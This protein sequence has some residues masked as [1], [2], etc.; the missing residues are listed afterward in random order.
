MSSDVQIDFDGSDLNGF[1]NSETFVK[2][3]LN[4]AL[5]TIGDLLR[6]ALK[7]NTPRRNGKLANST[8][9]Q[10][11]GSPDD[12]RL[13]VRQGARSE[14]GAFYGKFVREGTRPHTI[15]PKKAGGVLA[16][17]IGNRQMF[18]T[19]VNHPGTKPNPYHVKTLEQ[20]HGKIQEIV[21]DAGVDV[22]AKI[23]R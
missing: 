13:E 8:V 2:G 12:Q 14:G 20:K 15:L 22:A 23:T 5:R 7:A 19:K 21:S 16:F 9:Y 4:K 10:I 11:K 6:P 17:K 18:A 3:A 1:R